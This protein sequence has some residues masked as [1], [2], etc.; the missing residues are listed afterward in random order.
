MK[1]LLTISFPASGNVYQVPT[2]AVVEHRVMRKS[3]LDPC[4][5]QQHAA[6]TRDLFEVDENVVAYVRSEVRWPELLPYAVL[7]AHT[8]ADDAEHLAGAAAI[9][10]TDT[11]MPPPVLDAESMLSKP[12]ALSITSMAADQRTCSA[13]VIS[14]VATGAPVAGLALFRGAPDQIHGYIAVMQQ[15]EAFLQSQS[16]VQ[17][18]VLN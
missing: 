10:S 13:A 12:L 1:P 3:I 4:N 8:P 17:G 15:F 16:P 9:V 6:E 18:A 7:V 11:V 5:A 14:N 2:S